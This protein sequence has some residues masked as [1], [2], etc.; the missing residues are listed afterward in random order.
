MKRNGTEIYALA[1][2]F[3]AV[4]GIATTLAIAAYNLIG[5]LAPS[6]TIEPSR[7][8][9]YETNQAYARYWPK[10]KPIPTD[11]E[12]TEMRASEHRRALEVER[13]SSIQNVV[14]SLIIMFI[15][16]ALFAVHWRIKGRAK[17]S[18]EVA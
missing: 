15:A 2:C 10:D 4:I 5:A 13:R 9:S 3:V 1:V 17:L 14:K 7:I 16:F 11:A 8:D 18:H 6:F 12:L